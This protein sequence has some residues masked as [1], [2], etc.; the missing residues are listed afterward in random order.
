MCDFSRCTA[1]CSVCLNLN[2]LIFIFI[3]PRIPVTVN[4]FEDHVN[5]L[6]ANSNYGFSQEYSKINRDLT[7]PYSH[8]RLQENNIKNRYH[9]VPA[10][11]ETRVILQEVDGD[12]HSD[13]INANYIEGNLLCSLG[14]IGSIMKTLLLLGPGI[15]YRIYFVLLYLWFLP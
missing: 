10:Y 9:N 7:Y 4:R 8:S 11:D 5:Q 3:D 1:P 2:F 6:K 12:S 15:Y 14:S 13:Y